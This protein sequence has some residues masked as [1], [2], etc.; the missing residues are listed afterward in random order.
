MNRIAS[1]IKSALDE[2]HEQAALALFCTALGLELF[3]DFADSATVGIL[4][5]ACVTLFG[6]KRYQGFNLGHIG[7]AAAVLP[8]APADELEDEAEAPE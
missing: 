8:E 1:A 5:L 7:G 4:F 6:S 2:A 3:T